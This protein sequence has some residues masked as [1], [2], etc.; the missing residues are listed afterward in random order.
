[1][2][3]TLNIYMRLFSYIFSIFSLSLVLFSNLLL[4][5]Y[6]IGAVTKAVP[7]ENTVGKPLEINETPEKKAKE[8]LEEVKK[9]DP[10]ASE[11]LPVKSQ[12]LGDTDK[13]ENVKVGEKYTF[14]KN[15]LVTIKFTKL[16]E[17]VKNPFL[18]ITEKKITKNKVEVVGYELKTNMKNKKFKYD[19]TLPND[20]KSFDA[21]VSYTEDG[22]KTFK[23]LFSKQVGIDTV[24]LKGLNHF[25]IFI[26]TA[27]VPDSTQAVVI[28]EFLVNPVGSDK[29]WVELYNTTASDI[30]LAG[31]KLIDLANKTKTLSAANF[32]PNLILPAQGFGYY[33]ITEGWLNNSVRESI[34]LLDAENNLINKVDINNTSGGIVSTYP[35]ENQSVARTSDGGPN[36]IVMPAGKNTKGLSNADLTS[37]ASSGYSTVWVDND[38]ANPTSFADP[39]GAGNATQYECDSFNTIKEGIKAVI[40]GGTV[41][42]RDGIYNES[43]TI[44]KPLTINGN[45]STISPNGGVRL[46]ESIITGGG[47]VS[48]ATGT[49]GVTIQ[50]FTFDNVDIR[51]GNGP[52]NNVRIAKN[53]FVNLIAK[54]A[55]FYINLDLP[56]SSNY[57]IDD[58][59]AGVVTGGTASAFI[60]WGIDQ[61]SFTNNVIQGAPWSGIQL[62]TTTNSTI[63]GNTISNTG[64]H[65][66]QIANNSNN[67]LITGNSFSSLADS[68]V[69]DPSF[70]V[71]AIRIYNYSENIT[72]TNNDFSNVSRAIVGRD[73]GG[74]AEVKID[75]T[76]NNFGSNLLQVKENKVNHNCT[77]AKVTYPQQAAAVCGAQDNISNNN[78][79]QVRLANSDTTAP[80]VSVGSGN[81]GE[82]PENMT[83]YPFTP[84]KN[85]PTN[86]NGPAHNQKIKGTFDVWGTVNDT[87]GI[88]N[89][90]LRVI[91]DNTV[92]SSPWE[93]SVT[94]GGQHINPVGVY[95]CGFFAYTRGKPDSFTES[96]TQQKLAT[97]DTT[98]FSQGDGT[99]WIILGAQDENGNFSNTDTEYWHKDSRIRITI[100][101]T[102]PTLQF[103]D[104]NY[105]EILTSIPGDIQTPTSNPE[106]LPLTCAPNINLSDLQIP[107]NQGQKVIGRTCSITDSFG[108]QTSVNYSV[109]VNNVPPS[110]DINSTSTTLT[111]NVSGG[112]GP[113]TY[114][115]TGSCSGSNQT[116]NKPTSAG[117]YSCNIL[118]TDSDGDLTS[119]AIGFSVSSA[120]TGGNGGGSGTGGTGGGGSGGGSTPTSSPTLNQETTTETPLNSESVI[121]PSLET[122]P[123]QSTNLQTQSITPAGQVLGATETKN[124]A[125]KPVEFPW[126]L[127]IVLAITAILLI[128]FLITMRHNG[129]IKVIPVLV[130]LVAVGASIYIYFNQ[131]QNCP[132]G[133]PWWLIIILAIVNIAGSG[134]VIFKKQDEEK[135]EY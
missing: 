7:T 43:L 34:S 128:L 64:A 37:C 50:G 78:F 75:A 89:F 112:N 47:S 77:E 72:V 4:P 115:W 32:S 51:P 80:T 56:L 111:A 92:S 91:K 61:L 53:R 14:S 86:S 104:K 79:L 124:E 15:E 54:S 12:I 5:V 135:T 1:M 20:L 88:Q 10:Q 93:Q 42:V 87:N 120:P 127:V 52:V 48:I 57:T 23:Q 3:F 66:I 83:D 27:P 41:I 121:E 126:W 134:I 90:H 28:N 118:V 24:T 36:W 38:F 8:I 133:G 100:D 132:S 131:S 62:D 76:T 19:L 31:W 35:L 125:C 58:N 11:V 117:N 46:A 63:S 40:S 113:F 22:G 30:N 9:P 65:A 60:L 21:S 85:N 82:T 29:E 96:P 106:N 99:Y 97:I 49:S 18:T 81:N 44:N 114:K 69:N 110:V 2:E 94:C 17:K 84:V 103:Q 109:T 45:N 68:A 71:P 116:V 119:N 107:A 67:S 73:T 102:P 95:N 129:L 26:V 39:D 108:N 101:N 55:I 105:N 130:S 13:F 59:F 70:P 25:T 98:Q 123:I 16:D 74:A 6:A 33:P 122:L